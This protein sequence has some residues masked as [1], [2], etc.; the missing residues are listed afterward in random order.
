MENILAD[1]AVFLTEVTGG[2][3]VNF[4]YKI[5]RLPIA[6]GSYG[7]DSDFGYVCTVTFT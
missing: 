1:I 3:G 5:Y 7:T 2:V 4:H 6:V